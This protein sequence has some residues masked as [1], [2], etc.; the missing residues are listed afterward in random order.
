MTQAGIRYTIFDEE[1]DAGSGRFREWTLAIHWSLPTLRSIL[2]SHLAERLTEAQCDPTHTDDDAVQIYN[3]ESGQLLKE[4]GSPAGMKRLSRRKLRHLCVEGLDIQWGKTLSNITY[5]EDNTATAHFTDSTTITGSLIVGADGPR[6]KV[7][8]L[9]L[10]PEVAASKP[11]GVVQSM[12]LVKYPT[13]A[14]A[15]HVRSGKPLFYLGYHPAGIV[16]IVSVQDIPDPAKPEDWTFIVG[17]S[18]VGQRDT[19]LKNDDRLADIKKKAQGF[20]D[21]FRNASEWIPEGT[22]THHD[23]LQYWVTQKFDNKRGMV[24]LAGDAAHPMPPRKFLPVQAIVVALQ[25]IR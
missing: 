9:L 4:V 7:R 22:P 2:P 25:L 3:A 8:E 14:Q 15:L 21:P 10:G 11:V 23:Q 17:T 13:A 6:S 1:Q 16:N 19:S 5:A 18:W 20:A 12:T 24:T